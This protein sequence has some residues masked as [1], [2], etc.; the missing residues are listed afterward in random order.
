MI[1]EPTYGDLQDTLLPAWEAVVTSGLWRQ[2]NTKRGI[3][4][5]FRIGS[6][7]WFRSRQDKNTREDPP[8]RGQTVG[9]LI[10]D[11]LALAKRD[12]ILNI[13]MGMVRQ[14]GTK[15]LFIDGITTPK[16]NWLY[17]HIMSKGLADPVDWETGKNQIQVTADN[18]FAAFY[19]KTSHN[20]FNRGLDAKMREE[21][22]SEDA[23][24]ELDAGWV[25]KT[26]A[27]WNYVEE[28]WPRG[29]LLDK[30]YDQRKEFILSVDLGDTESCWQL[31]Q[32]ERVDGRQL[33]CLKAE[34]TPH[35]KEPW[36]V[37]DEI[38]RFVS[39]ARPQFRNPIE[40]HIGHDYGTPG[41]TGETADMM[42]AKMP[43]KWD[44]FVSMVTGWE[45]RKHV[46][47]M[48]ASY[49]LCNSAQHRTFVVSKQLK[50]FYTDKGRGIIEMLRHDTYPDPGASDHFRKEKKQGIF[51]EDSRDAF[52]YA[53][54]GVYPPDFKPTNHWGV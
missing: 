48:Q 50:S 11:E 17:R 49:L 32:F 10:H 1:T 41:N 18:K 8:F 7:V 45:G 20:K 43:E 37:L 6:Q 38:R 3:N 36:L 28:D 24:Q 53:C 23:L 4:M 22:S 9:G 54:V 42:F 16:P 12:D 14:Q 26:G 25:P 5:I 19:G 44:R 34:W 52:L 33:F 40:I 2:K 51:H 21:L 13:S 39:H 46:Q 29:N 35:G 47:D 15:M 30:P 31:Y 27:C